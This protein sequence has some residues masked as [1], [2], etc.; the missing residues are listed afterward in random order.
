[1]RRRN[2]FLCTVLFFVLSERGGKRDGRT[3]V[4]YRNAKRKILQKTE[5][6]VKSLQLWGT[7]KTDR[8]SFR[9]GMP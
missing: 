3:V 6:E 7:S 8:M 4:K 5:E 2:L 1:M 9:W